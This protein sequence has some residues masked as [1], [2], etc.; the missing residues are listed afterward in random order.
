[1]IEPLRNFFLSVAAH[2]GKIPF[3]GSADSTA[4]GRLNFRATQWGSV[5]AA[6]AECATEARVALEDLY[7]LYCSP[8]YAFT[9]RRGHGRHDAQDL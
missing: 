6:S 3:I 4:G 8:V 7:R 5:L 1:V 2:F 9:R